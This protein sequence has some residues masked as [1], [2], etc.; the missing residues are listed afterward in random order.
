MP[1]LPTIRV[2]GSQFISTSPLLSVLN[3]VAM[4]ALLLG[5]RPLVE[6]RRSVRSPTRLVASG[7]RAA[8]PSPLRLLVDGRIGE[9]A[10]RSHDAAD[11]TGGARRHL[12]ARW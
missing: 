1:R 6:I 3:A 4:F 7:E 10:Q 11:E 2:I 5:R 9:A 8:R 12:R